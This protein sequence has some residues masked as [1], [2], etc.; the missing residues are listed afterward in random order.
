[1]STPFP[2]TIGIVEDSAPFRNELEAFINSTTDLRCVCT[3][4]TGAAALE[5]IPRKAPQVI[6]MDL[7]LPDCTGIECTF[8]LKSMLPLTQFMIFTVQEDSEQ[9]FKAL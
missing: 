1:M 8:Q 6:L 3:C 5:E 7:Q 4:A 2:I 9:I